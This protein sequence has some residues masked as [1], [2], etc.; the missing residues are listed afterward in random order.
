MSTFDR[1]RLGVDDR[2]RLRSSVEEVLG[3]LRT[4]YRNAVRCQEH[5][6]RMRAWRALSRFVDERAVQVARI[7]LEQENVS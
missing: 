5:G 6:R 2:G 7:Q 4:N 3:M 1:R